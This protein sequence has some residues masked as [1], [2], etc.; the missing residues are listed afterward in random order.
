MKPAAEHMHGSSKQAHVW[1]LAMMV[2]L[3][4]AANMASADQTKSTTVW[5]GTVTLTGGFTVD[6]GDV[7]VIQAGTTVRIDPNERIWVNGRI[8][9]L[10]TNDSPVVFESS[11]A[12]DHEGLQFNFSSLGMNSV[13]DNLTI[14]D[15]IYG[16]TIFHSDPT[17]N[18][19]TIINA[20]RV[21]VDL[22]SHS[23]P[24]FNHLSIQG[25]G[26]DIHGSST[27]WRYGLGLSIGDGS[28]PIVR[29]LSIDGAMTRGL[30][31]WGGSGGLIFNSSISNI[32]GATLAASAGIWVE[33]SVPLISESLVSRSD[34]GVIVRHQSPGITTRPTFEGLVVEDSQYRG[35][36]VEQYNH[37]NYANLETIAIFKDIEV[38]GTG[39][40]E[41]K[42]PGLGYVAFDVNTTGVKI[43]EG[44]IEDNPVIGLRVFVSDSSTNLSGLRIRNNGNPS[45]TAPSHEGA[46]LLFRSTSWVQAGPPGVYDL[47]VE[48][49]SGTGVHMS[50]GGV[51]GSNWKINNNSGTG[52]YMKKFH[53]RI[54]HMEITNNSVN[55][56]A[57]IDSSNVELSHVYTSGNGIEGAIPEH[58]AGMYFSKSNY[59][60]SNGKNVSCIECSSI[61]D[62]HGIVIRDSID[63]QLISTTI[64]DSVS[65]P[66]LDIDN[67]GTNHAGSI[68]IEDMAVN[69]DEG[70]YLVYLDGVDAEI[71]DLDLGGETGGLFWEARGLT[72]SSLRDS[73]IWESEANC[74][75]MVGHTGMVASNVTL[76]CIQNS[77]SINSSMVGFTDSTLNRSPSKSDS[78]TMLGN[79]HLQ[80]ISSSNLITP[81]NGTSHDS[82]VDV[83]WT[84]DAHVINQN[85]L[86]IPFAEINTTFTLFEDDFNQTLPYSGLMELGPFVGKRWTPLSNWSSENTANIGCNYDGESNTSGPIN[87]DSDQRVYC[88]LDLSNQPPYIIW[89]DPENGAELPSGSELTFDASKSWDLDFDNLSFN[90]SS[91]ID[92]DILELC[93]SSIAANNSSFIVNS[94]D[95]PD[96][97]SDGLHSISL[98]VCDLIYNPQNIAIES[99]CVSETRQ[100]ELVNLPPVLSV[101]TNPDISSWGTL[102]LGETANVTVILNGTYDPE[103]GSLWCWVVASYETE[104]NLETGDPDCPMEITRS[105]NVSEADQFSVSVM[106]SDGVNPS[107]SWTFDVDL[108]NEIPDAKMEVS[109]N[110]NTSSD[111]IQLDGS[112]TIDPEGDDIKFEFWSDKDGLLGQG[113]TPEEQVE[114]IGTLSKGK[115]MISMKVSDNRTEHAGLWDAF[116]QEITVDN[117][118]PNA[119]ISSPLNGHQTDSSILTTFD[120]SGS[121]DWDL[122]CQDLPNNGSGIL[123]NPLVKSSDDI[124]SV[125][126]ESNNSDDPLGSDWAI[127]T[128]LSHG[129]HLITL[130][131]D[132][133]T[134]KRTS[135]ISVFVTE[136]APVLTLDSPL[137]NNEFKSNVPVTFDFRDSIDYDGNPFTVSLYSNLSGI[138]FEDAEKDN[139][140]D[141]FLV[142]GD[143][144]LRFV[145]VDSTGK[146]SE[147]TQKITITQTGPIAVIS[148]LEN[149]QYVPPGFDIEISAAESYDFDNDIVLYQ[150]MLPTGEIIGDRIKLEPDFSPGPVRID[151][152]VQDS[153]GDSSFASIN[154]TIGSSAPE[155]R[156]LEISIFEIKNGVSTD[157]MA[158][159]TLIDQD[160]TTEI[161]RGELTYGGQSESLY[162]RDDGSGGDLVAGDGIWTHRSNWIVSEGPW[163]KVEV[164]AVDSDLV[165]QG[166]VQSLPVQDKGS[167]L[168]HW[169]GST[170]LPLLGISALALGIA[171]LAFQRRRIE[172]IAQD[173]DMIESWSSFEPRELD[174]DFDK[175]NN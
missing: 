47:L 112:S 18:N 27:S 5:S 78:F 132:D 88:K 104:T 59:V 79:S 17:V 46:G 71:S 140:Y 92:G 131:I 38:R 170:I 90:W 63:L 39:G 1:I 83:M 141:E 122:A 127:S 52:A 64:Q 160:G 156:D 152:L 70:Q 10:G 138:I 159:V 119:I 173:M 65:L 87:I 43:I 16:L 151:L 149:G 116:E 148:G 35:V 100:I 115:H 22:F 147:H 106:A 162:F 81:S 58:S 174:S 20:D 36:L 6:S 171:G 93:G 133:G 86:N 164:W 55:G 54:E 12:D 8:N 66:A 23:S 98:E 96:C 107:V 117:S 14:K 31:I 113:S 50:L 42:T 82:I 129:N 69:S 9:V 124:V 130:T 135:S 168:P 57:V 154:L 67:Q 97:L 101:D 125:L 19:L 139:L 118:V 175:D 105:F 167:G 53:P 128:R 80:W 7:L 75:D 94:V 73:V 144:E 153:R 134:T 21:A 51:I 108:F 111:W 137:P 60:M 89:E 74:L 44:L 145:L 15:A 155:L 143:H 45:P 102:Y 28:A 163:A 49:S 24:I 33:D 110:G 3:T 68:L 161:V 77:P 109:R 34:N 121:G 142:H 62:Q 2:L 37:S 56:L 136:S 103:G 120:A 166:L 85:L 13:M 158:T 172:E 126:W 25:G 91:N 30:N 76:M 41:A 123:C 157:V 84:I 99:K 26:Q 48:N 146:S 114:W 40:P 165:S 61:G 150:W 11:G 169:L 29:N 4:P 32:S 72:D 95:K